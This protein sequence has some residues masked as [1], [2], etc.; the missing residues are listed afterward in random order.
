[1]TATT[2]AAD[3]RTNTRATEAASRPRPMDRPYFLGIWA[4]MVAG[5]VFVFSASF[6]VAGRPNELMMPGNPYHFL[7]LHTAYAILSLVAMLLTSL[8]R[9]TWLRRAA[10]PL[11]A[12][13]VVLLVLTL[14]EPFN[15]ELN[16]ARRWV[17]FP[18][19]PMFQPS[20]LA[21]IAYILLIASVL[22]RKDEVDETDSVA[23]LTVLVSMGILAAILLKQPD[24]G[25]T[26]VFVAITL[27][28]LFLSGMK[29][30]PFGTLV[31]TCTGL[32]LYFARSTPY[33]WRRIVALVDV[34]RASRDERYHIENM[35]IAQARGGITGTGLGMSPDKW[36]WLPAAHTDSIF[37]VIGC[38]LGLLGAVAVLV[39][40]LLLAVRG[41]H[42]A[43]K[44]RTPFSYY[45]ASGVAAMLALQ[46]LAHI[47]VNISLAPCTGLTLPFISG[48]GTSLL[49][50]AIAAGFVLSVSRYESGAEP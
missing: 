2:R 32:G 45:L 28:M 12:I 20:E 33:Q 19:L 49:S 7:L 39:G 4:M 1:M 42:I 30:L 48:G 40:V 38:E 43:R 50:A 18:G 23:Y 47:A 44:A 34:E 13:T 35:L 6:P 27:S 9:P 25:M 41:L 15:V 36:R 46:G 24:L 10:L 31:G 37:S 14:I 16:G 29:P 3:A 21:K 8:I 17:K 5:I 26:G 22:A 11:A